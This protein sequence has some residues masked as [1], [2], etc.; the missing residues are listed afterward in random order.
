[1]QHYVI[2]SADRLRFMPSLI[3]NVLGGV[4]LFLKQTMFYIAMMLITTEWEL[5]NTFYDENTAN[6]ESNI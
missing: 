4:F 5:E 2:V 3:E 1:M 6:F